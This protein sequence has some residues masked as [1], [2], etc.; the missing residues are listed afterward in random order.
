M[1]WG[2]GWRVS[3]TCGRVLLCLCAVRDILLVW[4][5]FLCGSVWIFLVGEEVVWYGTC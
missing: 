4:H 2:K 3:V 1:E 5:V